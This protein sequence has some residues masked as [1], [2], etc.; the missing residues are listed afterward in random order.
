MNSKFSLL[1]FIIIS[2]PL[3]AQN[4]IKVIS[5]DRN[6]IVIEYTP[7]YADSTTIKIDNQ[8]YIKYELLYGTVPEAEQ[9]GGPLL[10]VRSL[11]IG[12]PSETGNTLQVISSTYKIVQG[13]LAPRPRLKKNGKLSF[14]SY[15]V[16]KNYSLPSA[17]N[18]IIKFGRYGLMRSIPVQSVIVS[19]ME[20]NAAQRTI[21]LYTKIRFRVTFSGS[22]SIAGKPAEDLIKGAM[23]N[24]NV[25]KYWSKQSSSGSSLKKTTSVTG[26]V[27]SSGTWYRFEAPTEGIY[28]IT[29][30][31]LASYGIDPATV[32]PRTIKIY[33]N[34]G[35]VLSESITDTRPTDL[36]ENAILVV[37]QDDGKFD[38][39]DYILFYG[40]GNSF[41]D[42]DT[43]SGTFKRYFHPYS[44]Q[45]YYWITSGGST[46]KRMSEQTSLSSQSPYVQTYTQAFAQW[47]QDEI[48]IGKSGREYYGDNFS[49]TTTSRTYTTKLNGRLDAYPVNYRFRCIN[50]SPDYCGMEVD[51][52]STLISYQNMQGYCPG[53][54]DPTGAYLNG[55]SS[56]FSASYA[57]TL[58]DNRSVLKFTFTPAASASRGYLDYFEI[59]YKQQLAAVSDNLLFFSKDTTSVIR[60]NVTGFSS[61]N[62]KIFN[63]TDYSNARLLT[64]T[65]NG[66]EYDF[67]ASEK[68]GKVSRYFGVGNDVFLTPTNPAQMENSNLRGTVT[69]AKFLIITHKNFETAAKSLAAYKESSAP[70]KITTTVVDIDKIYNEFSCG[71]TDPTAMRDFIKYAYD[72]WQTTPSY[73]LFFG[74]GTY[75]AKDVDAVHNDYVPAYETQESLNQITS[76]TTDDYFVEVSGNDD[77]IDIPYGRITVE[78]PGDASTIVNKI[79]QYETQSDKGLWQNLI[80]LV[81]DDGWHGTDGWEGTEHTAPSE[82]LAN[83][84]IPTSYDLN[85]VYLAAYNTVLTSDGRRIPDAGTA[86]V[87]AINNGTLIMNFIG[88]GSPDLWADEHVFVQSTTIPQLKNSNYLFLI[89]ATCDFGYWDQ[90]SYQSS[91]EE[92]VLQSN[93]GCIAAF[94]STRLA[95]SYDNHQLDNELFKDLLLSTRDS[96]NLPVTLGQA[97]FQA[98]QV[99]S[100]DNARK[101][102][103]LGD[104]TLR[105]KIPQYSATIDTINGQVPTSSATVQIKALST[106]KVSGEIRK[107]DNSLW[108]DFNGNGILTMF[109]SQRS[110]D[111]VN[112]DNYSIILPGG[113]IFRGNISVT[114]GKFSTGFTVP[115]DISYENKNG[116]VVLYFYNSSLDG[117]GYTTNIIVGGTDTTAVNNKIGPDIKIYFDDTTTTNPKLVNP[118]SSLIV[119]LYD[120]NGLNTT[121][122]GIGHKLQGIL[123]G[124]NNNPIDF[125][126]Y[127]TSDVNSSGKSGVVNYKLSGLD[128]GTYSL[129]V[130]AWDVFNNSSNETITFDVINTNGL[131]ISDVYNYPDPFASNTMF[132]F[133]QNLASPI[134]VK[135]KV[136]TVAGRQIREIERYGITSKFVKVDWDGR[137]QNGDLIANGT[138]LYKV[139]VHSVDGKY[140]QSALGK[141]AKIH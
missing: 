108:S 22:Q 122:T 72:N 29:K 65:V 133:Q 118:T 5:S 28:K 101:Y 59:L 51:E 83:Y 128:P 119:K 85:K 8:N 140:N 2:I 61:S 38:D 54:V 78:S 49:Q 55:I 98:K 117:L 13:S 135:I 6:S 9:W 120:G 80:T 139:I 24:F 92:M 91:A 70:E 96:S 1:L 19:P 3:I 48:N 39:S 103:L 10:Q 126:N 43:A 52:S 50:A 4:D 82:Y 27:L 35:K 141:L 116:K 76:L 125:T 110:Y 36:V 74:K 88:H 95:Y 12:V 107:T 130:T 11:N 73:V 100:D 89:A 127:F 64:G 71:M 68:A 47:E 77:V 7:I 93:A 53:C 33:N 67:Q 123:N 90:P 94:T 17:E 20:Y 18:D 111:L 62:I 104:P 34:G 75:D 131:V 31:M 14:F 46:G 26:S 69:G 16:G 106:T 15:E 87:N 81:A 23:V 114:N 41:W 113:I 45:N 21:K 138:Y 102:G 97:V 136:Y 66:T 105:L 63:V 40:R 134:N 37:G 109:D 124:D 57:G 58:S 44:N 121:G 137:D 60:Y 99:Y 30:T 56:S 115:K 112:L 84:I 25:A 42:Y 79:I 32:D 86:I 132:T 129:K